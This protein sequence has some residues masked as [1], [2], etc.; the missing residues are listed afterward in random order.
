MICSDN[1]AGMIE[2]DS[3][4]IF[5]REFKV[6]GRVKDVRKWVRLL[7]VPVAK[8]IDSARKQTACF[9]VAPPVNIGQQGFVSVDAEYNLLF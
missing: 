9:N 5:R 8:V 1:L 4:Y 6:N 2:F 3:E 7:D